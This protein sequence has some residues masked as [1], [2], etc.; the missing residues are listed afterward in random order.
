MTDSQTLIDEAPLQDR[1]LL[2]R[3]NLYFDGFD[4]RLR[5]GQGWLIFNAR[6]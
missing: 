2:Q 6:G 4:Q 1:D 5:Q 3:M